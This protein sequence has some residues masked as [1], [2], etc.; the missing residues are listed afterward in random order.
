M[1]QSD[2]IIVPCCVVGILFAGIQ[3]NI[4]RKIEVEDM[5]LASC[6][7]LQPN[8]TPEKKAA[9]CYTRI[10]AG[11]KTFLREE[12]KIA[13][14]FCLLF[15][16]LIYGLVNWGADSKQGIATAI[17]FWVGAATSMLCGYLGMMIATFSNVRTTLSAKKPR[18]WICQSL[19]DCLPRRSGDGLSVVLSWCACFVGA[20]DRLQVLCVHQTRGASN[21]DGLRCRLWPGW[22]HC[23]NVWTRW[24]RNLHQGC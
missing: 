22:E 16:G 19:R 20:V 14:I 7:Q 9:A 2:Q 24:W 18:R 23:G 1:E 8:D 10:M 4:I 21:F 12:Y 6:D 13:G 17:A 11:A 3:Y 5:S 15:G